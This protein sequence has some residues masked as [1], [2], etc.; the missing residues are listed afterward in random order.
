MTNNILLYY[1]IKI[2]L[3]KK[4]LLKTFTFWRKLNVKKNLGYAMVEFLVQKTWW[5]EGEKK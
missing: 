3:K 5:R 4:K 2:Q 1:G